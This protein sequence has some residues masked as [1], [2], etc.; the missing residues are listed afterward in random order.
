MKKELLVQ[1][2]GAVDYNDRFRPG[3]RQEQATTKTI[4]KRMFTTVFGVIATNAYFAYRLETHSAA[5][6]DDER[7]DKL[8]FF[9][10]LNR[11]AQ[12]LITNKFDHDEP[13][14]SGLRSRS[15]PP[16]FSPG[17]RVPTLL[18]LN[19]VPSIRNRFDATSEQGR[20]A[21][22]KYQRYCA[23]CTVPNKTGRTSKVKQICMLLWSLSEANLLD[24]SFVN[25][26]F[27]K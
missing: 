2:F 24:G 23:T 18:A 17:L 1:H 22:Q 9:G 15:S 14:A 11:V 8:K 21:H 16:A 25:V 27:T 3:Y 26:P 4:W 5:T 12:Q 19:D 20:N 13:I 7:N 10:L 6:T